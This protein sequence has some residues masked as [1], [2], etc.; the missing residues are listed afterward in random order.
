M[1]NKYCI[2]LIFALSTL[3]SGCDDKTFQISV[4][5]SDKDQVTGGN[6]RIEVSIPSYLTGDDVEITLNDEDVKSSFSLNADG[7]A[8][9]GVVSGL[10][11]GEN[12]LEVSVTG[13]KAEFLTKAI[14]LTNHPLSGPIFSGPQQQPFY[15]YQD[16]LTDVG[17]GQAD[18]NCMTPKVVSFLYLTTE[19]SWSEYT[20]GMERPEN[21]ATTVTTDG[22]E[23]DFIVRWERGTLNRFIYSI[24]MLSSASQSLE[25]PDLNSW[26]KKLLFYF[27]GGVG[28]GHKQGEF[29]SR[30]ALFTEGLKRGYAVAY[31]TGTA[32]TTHY[33][34]QV[35]GETALMLKE[36]FIKEYALPKYSVAVGQ[37][38]GAVQQYMFAQNHKG[39]LD[40]IIPA[41]SYPDMVTQTTA[42]A[43]CSL[44]ERW[45]DFEIM[46]DADSKWTDWTK[47]TL[48]EGFNASNDISNQLF[49][50]GLTHPNLPNGSSECS[51]TWNGLVPLVFNPYWGT[52]DGVSDEDQVNTE[53]T[54]FADAINVYGVNEDGYANRTWDNVG[55]Q[56]GLGALTNG[57]ITPEEFLDLNFNA[58][59]LKQEADMI[60]EGCPFLTD[61]CFAIDPSQ[62]IWPEQ[63]DPWSARNMVLS[64]GEAPAPRATA[65][66]GAIQNAID[67]GLVNYGDIQIPTIDVRVDLERV[68]NMH[69]TKQSFATR[70]R[71]L[72]F[73]GDAS[74]QLIWFVNPTAEGRYFDPTPYAL[75]V[76]DEW[77]ENVQANPELTVVENR[78]AEA[79][80]ACF[81][82]DE[83]LTAS[84]D[85]VW[86]GIL[87]TT[88]EKGACAQVHTIY[89]NP[90]MVAGDSIAG[91]VF[92]CELQPVKTAIENG[93]YGEWNP[94]EDEVAQLNAIFPEGVCKF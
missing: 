26:N 8:F 2:G 46:A 39:L 73:D 43:D 33:N 69:N 25:S 72:N 70:Q 5:S 86:N 85:D 31:S 41:L 67:G 36:Q 81:A 74:N 34:L 63:V 10:N 3:L 21:M 84:G 65:D 23:V 37:S 66:E 28:V 9:N 27:Q 93:V 20:P 1:F 42:A 24:S 80:D 79:R 18:E 91:D 87:D 47:R 59:T 88:Q 12:N 53:W 50:Y 35:S 75:D 7:T 60:Q 56:Y 17:L 52:V 64:N 62:S 61:L 49:E 54:H 22:N 68:L 90:R 38:G 16:E 15:C 45:I 19:G 83:T 58:G 94:S 40:G 89:G 14:T 11:L 82:G 44:I 4:L 92:K 77:L 13:D 48:L 76:M 57:D 32:T 30:R 29:S 78:P 51:Q 6:A 55:V 71:M